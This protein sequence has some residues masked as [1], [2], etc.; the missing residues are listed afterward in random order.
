M[1]LLERIGT[2]VRANLNEMIDR[3]EDPGVML[4]QL[5]LDMENQLLQVKTQVAIAI[6][7][8]HLLQRKRADNQQK[9]AEFVHKAELAVEKNQDSLARVALERSLSHRQLADS[10]DQQLADQQVQVE[11]LKGALHKLEQ[12]LVETRAKS[13]LL[14]AQ[15]RRARAVEKAA[16]AQITSGGTSKL[17]RMEQK[18]LRAE[19]VAQAKSEMLGSGSEQQLEALAKDDQID[20]LLAEL[21]ARKRLEA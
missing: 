12:K 1:A 4:K 10:F 9:G 2:L 15:H 19:A 13:D 7:D 6:A 8:H 20:R 21:K 17:D 3:A 16:D 18:V 14:I 5:V 11:N